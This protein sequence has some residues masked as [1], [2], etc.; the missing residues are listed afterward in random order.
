MPSIFSIGL[1]AL[2][3]AQA[4]QATTGHNI[5]NAGTEGYNRQVTVQATNGAVAYG[6]GYIGMGTQIVD[7]KRIHNEL[8]NKQ[9]LSSQTSASYFTEYHTKISQLDDIVADSSAGMSPALQD[10]FSTIHELSTHPN[11]DSS[12]QAVLSGA[13]SLVDRF[14]SLNTV[15]E[16]SYSTINGQLISGA[17]TLSSY[18]TKIAELNKAIIKAEG[19][20]QHPPNDLLDQ[21]D[22]LLAELNKLVKVTSIKESNGSLSVYMGSGQPLVMGTDK[23]TITTVASVDDPTRLQLAYEFKGNNGPIVIPDKLF[24]GGSIGGILDYRTNTLDPARNQLGRVATALAMSFNEQHK[25]GI[26]QN[27][28]QG[29]D[30]FTIPEPTVA[31]RLGNSATASLSATIADY[32]K[33]E[34]SDYRVD[35]NGTDYT[36]T[37]LSDN[38]KTVI[39][40]PGGTFPVTIDGVEFSAPTM[41]AGD[42]FT[43]KPTAY[44]AGQIQLALTNTKD[45][46]AGTPIVTSAQNIDQMG[47]VTTGNAGSGAIASTSINKSTFVPG[48]QLTFTYNAGNLVLNPP[49]DV[50][51]TTHLGQ[52]TTYPSGTP[53][54]YSEGSTISSGGISF[55]MS[56]VPANGDTFEFNP[57]AAN[58][59][60]GAISAGRVDENYFGAPLAAG[61]TLDFQYDS[62]TNTFTPSAS[63]GAVAVTHKD[64]TT[65]NYAAGAAITYTEGDTFTTGGIS[66]TMTG[67]PSNGD[68]FSVGVNV[69]GAGDNRNANLLAGLQTT[70]TI[71]KTTFQGSYSA[72]VSFI[73]N[74]TKEIQV[75]GDAEAARYASLYA[76]QQSES[77]VN[78]DEELANM[79]KNQY[80]Y[81]GAAKVIQSASDMFDVIFSIK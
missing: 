67:R 42:V 13:Q 70:E 28:L 74:K 59:G 65:T 31:G 26:D 49:A 25:Q 4:A 2:S 66:F 1:S 69:D 68:K 60:T 15:L 62:A 75:L 44:S 8:L 57:V 56:G 11:A 54:P 39:S 58:T 3:A 78:R 35:Y 81:Q 20:S 32:T 46:A 79:I 21:R 10:F 38:N 76:Q 50:T 45:I 33:L 73:G 12:R 9:V 7:V 63:V 36:I 55:L 71:G 18:A 47:L 53:I 29:R 72:M 34:A 17:T 30:F 43:V 22:Q 52:T 24:K 77:G 27:G 37:R 48:S 23:A 41:A 5:A 14:H 16:Q 51:V 6:Y 64:G 40:P 61:T 19:S 80:A